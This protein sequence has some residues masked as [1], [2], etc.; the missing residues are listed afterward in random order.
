LGSKTTLFWASKRRRFGPFI[1]N[2]FLKKKKKKK[3]KEKRKMKIIKR[4][5]GVC[6]A[7]WG[8]PDH[9]QGP[10]KKNSQSQGASVL[11]FSQQEED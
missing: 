2:F 9:P 1:I 11:D 7:F 3:R 8:W 10:E 5:G 6:L 4:G